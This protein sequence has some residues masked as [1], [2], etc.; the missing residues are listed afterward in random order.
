MNKKEQL[1]DKSIIKQALTKN[2]LPV[3]LTIKKYNSGQ[4]NRVYNIGNKYI[5]KIE[6]KERK[7][8]CLKGQKKIS[9]KLIM[10]GAKTPKIIQEAVYKGHR[11]LIMEKLPGQNLSHIWWK[12]SK[13]EKES[14]IEQ[15][16]KQLKIYH[17]IKFKDFS[18]RA[19]RGKVFPTMKEAIISDTDFNDIDYEKLKPEYKKMI[20]YLKD[21]FKENV[22]ILDSDKHSVFVHNDVHFENILVKDNKIVGIIDIDRWSRANPDYEI[23][24]IFEFFHSPMKFVEPRLEHHYPGLMTEEVKMVK[25]Y[26]PEIFGK[27]FLTRYRVC[28]VQTLIWLVNCCQ[29]GRWS[30]NVM[31]YALEIVENVYTDDWLKK[32]LDGDNRK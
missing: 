2:N 21:Y 22:D 20:N 9:E 23:H 6:N 13:K 14:I 5:V 8:N 10:A 4:T 16:A 12:K 18:L 29:S 28:Y 3:D 31:K 7:E 26:Y 17:S 11:Y 32:A 27:D 30:E 1:I 24:K 19:F 25:K 15:L